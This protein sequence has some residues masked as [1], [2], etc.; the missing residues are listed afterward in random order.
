MKSTLLSLCWV[1]SLLGCATGDV[2]PTASV[3]Q[4]V[5]ATDP[6]DHGVLPW[7][8]PEV[9][10]LTSGAGFHAWQLTV[11]QD[12]TAT[13]ATSPAGTA[14]VDTALQLYRQQP[15]GS[16]GAALASNNDGPTPPWSQLVRALPAGTYRVLVKRASRAVTGAFALT[17][18]CSGAGCATCAPEP[19]Q[20]T[21]EDASALD[22]AIATFNA[23]ARNGFDWCGLA[24]PSRYST[25]A[26]P[27]QSVDLQT[28]VEQVIATDQNLGGYGFAD[29]AVQTAAEIAAALPFGTS[30]SS[31]GPAVAQAVR[32]HVSGAQPQG[33]LITS[34]VPCHNCHEFLSYLVLWYPDGQV[35]VLP[36]LT[37]YDS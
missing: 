7:G 30:C 25:P 18:S 22:P 12:V 34:E 16:W 9:A 37:G 1:F 29:G 10:T 36:Y 21:E 14:A 35:L 26:C 11:A 6:I 27:E 24:S 33:W 2:E 13:F 8:V 17:A 31:G 15:D 5:S 19:L 28:I 4:A 32:D 3:G 23:G 20:L